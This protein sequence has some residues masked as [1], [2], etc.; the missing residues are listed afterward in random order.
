MFSGVQELIS[1]LFTLQHLNLQ[2]PLLNLPLFSYCNK[3]D[4]WPCS[5]HDFITSLVHSALLKLLPKG[6]LSVTRP[7]LC[8]A[9]LAVMVR[10]Q[11]VCYVSRVPLGVP[12]WPILLEFCVVTPGAYFPDD[13]CICSWFCLVDLCILMFWIFIIRLSALLDITLRLRSVWPI[14]LDSPYLLFHLS[15]C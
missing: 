10:T 2:K 15:H 1:W 6:L 4:Y 9:E 14:R 12:Q 3:L 8:R 13:C 7:E 5:R 11:H